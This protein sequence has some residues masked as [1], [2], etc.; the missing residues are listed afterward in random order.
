MRA[1]LCAGLPIRS[2]RVLGVS[3]RRTGRVI[4]TPPAVS[5]QE[6]RRYPVTSYEMV[7]RVLNLRAARG[8]ATL[9]HGRHVET[10]TAIE[11]PLE[12]TAQVFRASLI[13]GPPR[14]PK[15]V[16]ALYRRLFVLPYPDA[17]PDSSP[18]Q[19]ID[20]AR[21]HPVFEIAST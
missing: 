3:G 16:V 15:L 20:D 12:R 6:G 21:T 4:E 1:V 11:L 8:R 19:F 10:V 9:R 14:A 5:A 2:F 7:N 18:E 17:A 13:S